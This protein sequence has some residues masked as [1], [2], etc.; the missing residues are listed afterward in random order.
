[1]L[2]MAVVDPYAP[3]PC[4]SGQKFKWCC[5]KVEP[6]AEKA[7]RLYEGNQADAALATLDEGLRKVPGNPWLLVRKALIHERREEP[8]KARPLLEQVLVA[9]PNHVG[10]QALLVRVVTEDEGP[11]GGVAQLQRALTALPDE[12]RGAVAPLTQMIA[13]LL[14]RADC[15]PAALAHLEL[16]EALGLDDEA[17]TESIRRMLEGDPAVSPWQKNPYDLAAAPAGL[18]EAHAGRFAEAL[19][20]AESGLWQSAAAAFEALSAGAGGAE[21]DRNL[22]LCRLWLADEAGAVQ[23]LRRSIARSGPTAE[24]VDLEALCQL[25]APPYREDQVEHFH[26]IWPLRDRG[27]LMAILQGRADVQYEGRGPIEP[28]KEDSPEVDVFALMDRPR[29]DPG[30]VPDRPEAMPRVLGRVLVGQEIASLDAFEDGR[31]DALTEHFREVAGTAIPPAHPKTKVVEK[32]SRSAVAMA[33]EWV[34][35]EG[36]DRAALTRLNHQENRRVIQEVWPKTPM[37]YLNGRT[38]EQAAKAGDAAVPLRAALC[39]FEANRGSW[40]EEIDFEALR[41]SLNVPPEPEVDAEVDVETVHLGRLHRVPAERLDD[42]RL[43]ALYLRAREYV[44]PQAMERA[45]RSLVERPLPADRAHVDRFAVYSDLANLAVGRDEV[46]EASSWVERGRAAEPAALRARNAPRWDMLTVRLRARSE[47]PEAWVAQLAI[48]LERYSQD[49]TASQAIMGNLLDM[50][51]VQLVP[52][53]DRPD[54]VLMDTRGLQALLTRYGP[55]VTTTSGGLGV[56]ATKPEIWTPGAAAS[57]G[58]VGGIWTPGSAAPSE[59]EKPKLIIP[60]R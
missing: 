45:A 32:V 35:P 18:S 13:M 17:T 24:A 7:E 56:S 42:D 25:I 6:Y 21:V 54:D 27:R 30:T 16:A 43:A 1:M 2:A 3:C 8:A 28:E 58:G 37:P 22:G 48:I 41:R 19:E 9:Q 20:W 59:A 34:I 57:G 49:R 11:V 38:P 46:A 15:I 33:T 44:L 31:L 4:G 12:A 29:L 55:R 10:A 53:P 47:P 60:G 23:A 40:R 52:N 36:L 5:H 26:L 39:Q 50:G 14:G 51:L